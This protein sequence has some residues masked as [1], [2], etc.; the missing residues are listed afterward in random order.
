LTTAAGNWRDSLDDHELQ[1]PDQT[2]N[3][4]ER[5]QS[6]QAL[7]CVCDEWEPLD[8][9]L[10]LDCNHTYCSSCLA[11]FIR[12]CID[13]SSRFPPQCCNMPIAIENCR[14]LL[15]DEHIDEFY[16]KQEELSTRNPTHCSSCGKF[17]RPRYILNQV[18]TCGFCNAETCSACKGPVHAGLCEEDGNV[19]LLR[20]LARQNGWRQC[21][22]CRN[23]VELV[24]GCYHITYVFNYF[25]TSGNEPLLT[26]SK[27][28]G[29]PTSS[30]TSAEW[31]GKPATADSSKTTRVT[32]RT[33]LKA[34]PEESPT[35]LT[36]M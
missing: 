2:N 13:D 19:R 20:D 15:S 35:C 8:V 32:I 30:A 33:I 11:C 10:T 9:T 16:L 22:R 36:G 4:D 29:A 18:A 27:D 6:G 24:T 17:I 28:V 25:D 26:S 14:G 21:G 31:N 7:C 3:G 12:G 23:M 1:Q 5:K 34:G